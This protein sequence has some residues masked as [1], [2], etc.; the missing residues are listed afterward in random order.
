[1]I[2]FD[3]EVQVTEDFGKWDNDKRLDLIRCIVDGKSWMFEG[4]DT[5]TYEPQDYP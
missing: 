5:V 4:T 2:E 1:M 3:T